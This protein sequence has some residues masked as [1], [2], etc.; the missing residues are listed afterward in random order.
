MPGKAPS[1]ANGWLVLFRS[2]DPTVWNTDSP[3]EKRYAI[4]VARAPNSIRYV[5]LKR[6]DTGEMQILP[7]RHA[8]LAESPKLIGA[9]PFVWN[10]AANVAHAGRHLG[11]A[12]SRPIR[13]PRAKGPPG[14]GPPQRH[15][16]PK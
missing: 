10:G 14:K 9:E 3:D 11:I 1:T 13:G 15:P 6:M 8:Q 7:I 5:R 16:P 2:D 12:E 4:P